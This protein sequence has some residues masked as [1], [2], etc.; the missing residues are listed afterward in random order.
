M[1]T[2]IGQAVSE[3][4]SRYERKYQDEELA[5]LATGVVLSELLAAADTPSPPVTRPRPLR[6]AA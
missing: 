6:R 5:A 4:F 2:T 3:L 1:K